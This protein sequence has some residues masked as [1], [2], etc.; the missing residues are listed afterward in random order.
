MKNLLENYEQRE[1]LLRLFRELA[2]LVGEEQTEDNIN[3]EDVITMKLSRLLPFKDQQE[4][5]HWLDVCQGFKFW[6]DFEELTLEII[7]RSSTTKEDL[8]DLLEHYNQVAQDICKDAN[9]F[10]LFDIFERLSHGWVK[11]MG[12]WRNHLNYLKTD[13]D[14]QFFLQD[15]KEQYKKDFNEK[16][17]YKLNAYGFEC[18]DGCFFYKPT[19]EGKSDLLDCIFERYI[20]GL[21][22]QEELYFY[23][24]LIKELI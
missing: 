2:F 17:L 11:N 13:G 15:Y 20:E 12:E 21:N 10:E 22:Q 24:R 6:E 7:D 4:K 1:R 14:F 9:F 19:T 16:D 18:Y 3:R 8:K 5:E 23:Q